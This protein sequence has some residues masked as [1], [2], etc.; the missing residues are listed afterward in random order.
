MRVT[1]L[2][3]FAG[4]ASSAFAADAS[5]EGA[6]DPAPV[7]APVLSVPTSFDLDHGTWGAPIFRPATLQ[8]E[9]NNLAADED[10]KGTGNTEFRFGIQPIF[11]LGTW[12]DGR[13]NTFTNFRLG[14][15]ANARLFSTNRFGWVAMGYTQFEY[16]FG[17]SRNG[18]DFMFGARGGAKLAFFSI[19][20]G[21]EFWGNGLV[22]GTR[23]YGQAW[24][25]GV[26]VLGIFD[27]RFVEIWGGLTPAWFINN[28]DGRQS[29]DWSESRVKGFG[30]EME[31]LGGI[32]FS[33]A[34]LRIGV[35]VRSRTG[36]YGTVNT[37]QLYL[38]G[39]PKWLRF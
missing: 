30:D 34:F 19:L 22:L 1:A 3:L 23:D 25:L 7:E 35:G 2:A 20:T 33:V 18:W 32:R 28:P 39:G 15:N 26:P 13:G 38:G 10:V 9:G 24:L 21:A 37:W 5:P 16:M 14:L 11:G 4:L 29:T 27:F 12:N 6:D 31:Y 17:S 8:G 36:S